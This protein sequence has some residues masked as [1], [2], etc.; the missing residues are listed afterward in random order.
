MTDLLHS[1]FGSLLC[2]ATPPHPI[3]GWWWSSRSAPL[4]P[5]CSAPPFQVGQHGKQMEIERGNGQWEAE[6]KNAPPIVFFFSPARH[7]VPTARRGGE[8]TGSSRPIRGCSC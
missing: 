3:G 2:S 7:A 8:T 6:P 4:A 1:T 5:P